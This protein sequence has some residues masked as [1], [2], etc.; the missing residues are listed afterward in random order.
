MKAKKFLLTG[1]V[2][3]INA[4]FIFAAE[5]L[6]QLDN[7]QLFVQKSPQAVFELVDANGTADFEN[8]SVGYWNKLLAEANLERADKKN[9]FCL[10]VVVGIK[11]KRKRLYGRM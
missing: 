11:L 9:Y 5:A 3:F 2:F 1:L 10:A 6:Q 4:F 8:V 7:W